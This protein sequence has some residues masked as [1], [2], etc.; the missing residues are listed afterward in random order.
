MENGFSGNRSIDINMRAHVFYEVVK[1]E[2]QILST[3]NH[4]ET[5]VFF[6]EDVLQPLCVC[7]YVENRAGSYLFKV[8]ID[9]FWR[10]NS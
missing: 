2:A 8:C 10:R 6:Q 4:S 3:K 5:S 7:L 9:P 1:L